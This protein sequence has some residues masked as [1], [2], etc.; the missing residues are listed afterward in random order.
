MHIP[1]ISD[2]DYSLSSDDSAVSGS[3][4]DK[5]LVKWK[6]KQWCSQGQ[7]Q[8]PPDSSLLTLLSSSF[9]V[10]WKA[11]NPPLNEHNLLYYVSLDKEDQIN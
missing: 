3:P 9:G 11:N 4:G 5:V 8:S 1:T 10:N 7:S 6:H 2:F